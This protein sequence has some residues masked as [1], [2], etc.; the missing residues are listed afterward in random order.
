[1][2]AEPGPALVKVEV[3]GMCHTDVPA[4]QNDWPVATSA[5]STAG[6]VVETAVAPVAD[7]E[8]EIFDLTME[9]G[10]EGEMAAR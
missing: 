3:S 7:V 5:R 10:A 9:L 1:M 4:A 6:I 8:D 2:S